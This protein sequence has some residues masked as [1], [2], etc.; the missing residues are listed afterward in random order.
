MI[1]VSPLHKDANIRKIL[2][3]RFKSDQKY[4]KHLCS[5][6]LLGHTGPF[7]DIF[8]AVLWCISEYQTQPDS[9]FL[10]L[11]GKFHFFFSSAC[12]P[13]RFDM[14]ICLGAGSDY[15]INPSCLL[16]TYTKGADHNAPW[17]KK[18]H[19]I[20]RAMSQNGF[21]P[22]AKTGLEIGE[23]INFCKNLEKIHKKLG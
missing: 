14:Y 5:Q 10:D 17:I 3:L 16:V 9:S 23:K 4:C 11:V 13:E 6:V 18:G 22:P 21:A 8:T 15:Q 12:L 2:S 1:G 20:L 7:G 19:E